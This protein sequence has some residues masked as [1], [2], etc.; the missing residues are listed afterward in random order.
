[1]TFQG[2]IRL[3]RRIEGVGRAVTV[4]RIGLQSSRLPFALHSHT[5]SL[6]LFRPLTL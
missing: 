6:S 3:I 1:M 5:V 4:F 2:G